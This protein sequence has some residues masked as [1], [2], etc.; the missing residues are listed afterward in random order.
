MI[1]ELIFG[2]KKFYEGDMPNY[3]GKT[4][5]PPH[6]T[7]LGYDQFANYGGTYGSFNYGSG[8]RE[9]KIMGVAKDSRGKTAVLI[10]A[11]WIYINELFQNGGGI[12]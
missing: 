12:S 7:M 4:I 2:S 10:S 3:I 8:N 6:K 11:G 5:I 1:K 9:E